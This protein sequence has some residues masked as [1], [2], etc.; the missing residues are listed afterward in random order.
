MYR[1]YRGLRITAAFP[2]D[3]E[4][5]TMST[6]RGNLSINRENIFTIIK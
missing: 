6:E 3:K 2:M 5:K 4:E 1:K